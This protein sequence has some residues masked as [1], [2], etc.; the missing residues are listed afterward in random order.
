MDMLIGAASFLCGVL[1]MFALHRVI[2]DHY[3]AEA[4]AE[5][6]ELKR[7]LNNST[8]IEIMHTFAS[9]DDVSD[10]KFF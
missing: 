7:Q 4:E 8:N 2:F 1:T 6:K 9:P 3:A 10:L 5:I